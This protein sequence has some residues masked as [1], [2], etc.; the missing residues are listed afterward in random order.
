MK[1]LIYLLVALLSYSLASQAQYLD[2][3]DPTFGDKGVSKYG[4][5]AE[6]DN[7]ELT[8]GTL[9]PDG[10]ILAVSGTKLLRFN[11]DGSLDKTFADGGIFSEVLR[12]NND[13]L[14]DFSKGYRYGFSSVA[15][16][17]DNKIIVVGTADIAHYPVAVP[18]IFR[19]SEDGKIDTT[20]AKKGIFCNNSMGPMYFGVSA[21]LY[22]RY[23]K[24]HSDGKLVILGYSDWFDDPQ[25]LLRFNPNGTP[26]SSFGINGLV[27][28]KLA[29]ANGKEGELAILPSGH[30]LAPFKRF[31]VAKYLS[32][33]DL[34]TSF[35][36][37][38]MLSLFSAF[39][40]PFSRAMVVQADG[41]IVLAGYPLFDDTKPTIIARLNVDGTIDKTFDPT[42][43][44]EY[45]WDTG[46]NYFADAIQIKSDKLVL[47]ASV[48]NPTTNIFNVGLMC[49]NPDGSKNLSFGKMG[50][51]LTAPNEANELGVGVR[52]LLLQ[53][54]FKIL[55]LGNSS[56]TFAPKYSA[57]ATIL[58][59]NADGKTSISELPKNKSEPLSIYP[60][61]ASDW[62]EI[63]TQLPPDRVTISNLQGQ[64]VHV[65]AKTQQNKF[66]V[67]NLTNGFY[68]I[69]IQQK[70]QI[71]YQ[72][73]IIQ[74]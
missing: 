62:I 30:I 23:V 21:P 37:T 22:T 44:R 61:P 17:S 56:S 29:E 67:S 73:L 46:G 48:K 7:W 72:K 12:D 42:G 8:N 14:L 57:Y 40:S 3:L 16:Q 45:M 43:I 58:R 27:E 59:Y 33:G 63:N 4:A 10:K 52:K 20:F 55:T 25:V 69:S 32:N 50:K 31:G 74:H 66:D 34:D 2:G 9:A 47:A 5:F 71:Q 54:D 11:S 49:I 36:H 70:E 51:V 41:K 65:W 18:L 64:L 1:H 68:I 38:G 19:L 60:N 35:N 13:T 26:D 6:S 39:G 24:I 53:K 15:I 28:N